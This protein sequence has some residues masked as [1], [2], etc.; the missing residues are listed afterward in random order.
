MNSEK[1]V[2]LLIILWF[3]VLGIISLVVHQTPKDAVRLLLNVILCWFLYK[4]HN[5][6]RLVMG[7]LSLLAVIVVSFLILTMKPE[8]NFYLLFVIVTAIGYAL[9]G[10]ILF[11]K[12]FISAHF[13]DEN[14]KGM[15]LKT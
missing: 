9:S 4:G 7:V 10:Y 11:S 12:K 15:D 2:V 1:K 5:W 6:S 14:I 8:V 13:D 3:L